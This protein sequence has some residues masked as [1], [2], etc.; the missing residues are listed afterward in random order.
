M[1]RLPE[2]LRPFFGPLKSIYTI[3]TWTV[4]PVTVRMSA[5][6]GGWLPTG[7]AKT[8]EDAALDGGTFT[9]ARPEEDLPRARPVG[10]PERYWAFEE[11]LDDTVPRVGVVELEGGRVLQPHAVVITKEN[12]QLYETS[13][14][15]GTKRPREHPIFLNPFPPD[16]VEFP[17]R[18][19]VLASR[20]DANYYHFMHDVLPRTSVLEQAGVEPPDRWYVPAGTKWQREMLSLWGIEEDQI[21]DSSAVPHVR[22]ERL[23]VPGLASMVEHNPPWVARLLREKLV[24]AGLER[25]P[26]KHLFLSRGPGKNNRSVTN[27]PEVRALL[28]PLGFSVVDPGTMTIAEQIHL[29]ATADIVVGPHGAALANIAFCSPGSALVELFPC[30]SIAGDFWKASCGVEG[31]EYRYVSGVGKRVGTTRSEFVV[32][33]ITVDLPA[34]ESTVSDLLA[35]R[36][37]RPEHR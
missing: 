7:T 17:G 28:E 32:A 1:V 3:G 25:T 24:P 5:C 37:S 15:F 19:G 34:L 26:G 27:E 36:E 13:W 31:L 21:L 18:L 4:S 35:A 9:L 22:A 8:M 2:Q 11:A 10:F 30:G 20:G 29:F 33:D 14:Y 16:P 6:R 12:R 23:V